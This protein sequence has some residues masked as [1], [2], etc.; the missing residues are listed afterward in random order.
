MSII[1][2]AQEAKEMKN[3]LNLSEDKVV[4]DIVH[5][6]T[7]TMLTLRHEAEK[8]KGVQQEFASAVARYVGSMPFV[9][10]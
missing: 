9:F 5:K 7:R 6:N 3:T 4:A 8:K 2:N 10:I 1:K